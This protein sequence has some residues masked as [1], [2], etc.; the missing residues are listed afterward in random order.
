MNKTEAYIE[1]IAD[2]DMNKFKSEIVCL[3]NQQAM[4]YGCLMQKYI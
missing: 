3:I 2:I 4:S 1:G